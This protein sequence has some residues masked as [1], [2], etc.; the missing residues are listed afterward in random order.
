MEG[1]YHPADTSTA[2]LPCSSIERHYHPADISTAHPTLL[3][4]EGHYRPAD[5][6]TTRL[7]LLLHRRSLPPCRHFNSPS[8]FA[9][10]WKVTITLPTL[11]QPVLLCSS[12]EGHY[13]P[14]DTSTACLTLLLHRRSLPPCRHFYSPSY[15]APP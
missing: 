6:S 13:R 5:T 2:V 9:P 11:L 4:I 8:Y 1:H 12:I 7:T 10:S 14:A 3:S 15:F